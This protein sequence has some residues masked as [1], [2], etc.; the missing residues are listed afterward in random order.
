MKIHYHTELASTNDTAKHYAQNGAPSLSVIQA[1]TQTAGR[2][3]LGRPW[4]SLA[5]NLFW[6]MI[7]RP[8]HTA[9][10]P[11]TLSQIAAMSIYQ[12]ICHFAGRDV[13]DLSLKWPNDILFKG[14]KL[15]GILLE[16][17]GLSVTPSS[18]KPH[19]SW[20][21]IGIGVNLLHSP[22]SDIRYPATNLHAS[23]LFQ[24]ESATLEGSDPRCFG[25]KLAQI[26]RDNIAIW[27]EQDLAPFLS[28]LNDKLFGIGG[29]IHVR[30][31]DHDHTPKTGI[32]KGISPAGHLILE[33]ESGLCETLTAGDVTYPFLK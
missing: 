32:L 6:S 11:E 4:H 2:G 24:T 31:S 5:G 13:H 12:C 10:S 20:V 14:Q 21:V 25:Q 23:G 16:S 7:V 3:R 30:L 26:I 27:E 9:P 15:S 28:F 18:A 33:L 22:S 8:K 19:F 17:G 1:E 29:P